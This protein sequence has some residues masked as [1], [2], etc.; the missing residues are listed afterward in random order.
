M[1]AVRKRPGMFI[2]STGERGLHRLVFEIASCSVNDV[3]VGRATRV[4]VTLLPDGGVRVADDGPGLPLDNT[5][6]RGISELE[7]LL[8]YMHYM[9]TRGPR[10]PVLDLL[11]VGPSVVNALSS[12]MLAEVQREGVRRVQRYACG[13]AVAPPADA[14]PAAD[15]RTAISFWPDP[16]IFETT[17]FS[18]DVL[19]ERFRELAFLYRD[20]DISLTDERDPAEPRSVRFCFPGGVQDMVAHLDEHDEHLHPDIVA[21]EQEDPRMEGTMEVALR[22]R[23]S[24]QEQTR[25][26]ANS[27]PTPGGGTHVA[28]FRNGLE[29]AVNAYARERGLLTETDPDFSSARIGEGLTAVVSVKL[30]RPRFEGATHGVLHNAEVLDCV[31]EAVAEQVGKWLTECPQ[32]AALVL[33]RIA[34]ELT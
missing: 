21:F 17:R 4:E 29:A 16:E 1:E 33:D 25:S 27:V 7:A 8:T 30:K 5:T 9:P 15:T 6:I 31:R 2:G 14:G 12:R 32:Q 23:G 34:H 20:L 3:L 28:G 11:G 26:F 10:Y 22:W 19:A 18:F 24:G 13:V